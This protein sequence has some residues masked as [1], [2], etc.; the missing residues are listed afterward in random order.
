[1]TTIVDADTIEHWV[2]RVFDL[3]EGYRRSI[4]L[5]ADQRLA[6]PA[7]EEEI[8]AIERRFDIELPRSYRLFLSLH[9]GW[10]GYLGD[11]DLMSTR[12]MVSGPYARKL[13]AWRKAMFAQGRALPITG[14]AVGAELSG[15]MVVLLDRES[16]HGDEMDIVQWEFDETLR[17]VSFLEQLQAR[18]DALERLLAEEESEL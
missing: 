8:R 9:D 16:R 14:F 13:S 11:V 6:P 15:N 18:A 3:N 7:S 5:D 17:H 1:M 4:E 10:K 12:E 2:R